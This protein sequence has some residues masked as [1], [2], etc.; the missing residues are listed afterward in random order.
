MSVRA[1]TVSVPCR[2]VA[3]DSLEVVPFLSL[4]TTVAG[5]V[6]TGRLNMKTVAANITGSKAMAMRRGHH[7]SVKGSSRRKIGAATHGRA[8]LSHNSFTSAI[9]IRPRKPS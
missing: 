7:A 3:T 8:E 6:I 4:S 1:V 9:V 2:R 5:V